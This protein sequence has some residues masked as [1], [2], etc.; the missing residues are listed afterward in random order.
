MTRGRAVIASAAFVVLTSPSC[1]LNLAKDQAATVSTNQCTSDSDCGTGACFSGACVAT[2]GTL[3]TLL[4]EVTPPTSAQGVGGVRFLQVSTGLARSSEGLTVDLGRVSTVHGFVRASDALRAKGCNLASGTLAVEVTLTPKQQSYGLPTV[5]YVARTQATTVSTACQN[6]IPSAAG[7]IQEFSLSVPAGSYDV[8]VRPL[9]TTTAGASSDVTDAGAGTIAGCTLPPEIVHG[10]SP[11][12]GDFCLALSATTP[13]E[14]NVEVPW[15]A[16][17]ATLDGWTVQVVHPVTGE[18]LSGTTTLTGRPSAIDSGTGYTTTVDYSPIAGDDT[19][20]AGQELL[21]LSPKDP[22]ASPVVQLELA[23]LQAFSANHK[24][25]LPIIGPFPDP[26]TVDSWVWYAATDPP[27]PALGSVAFAATALD[28]IAGG[29]FASFSTTAVVGTDGHLITKV[30][31]GEY[32]VRVTPTVGQHLASTE[33]SESIAS[34]ATQAGRALLVPAA[35]TVTGRVRM[36][37]GN[38]ALD[39]ASV[40]ASPA[41]VGLRQCEEGADAAAC[42]AEPLGVLNVSL[43][44][45]A[46]VPRLA[47]G[48]VDGGKLTLSDV[49]CGGCTPSTAASFDLSVEP[50]DGSRLPWLIRRSVSVSGNLDLGV[51]RLPFPVIQHG[52]VEIPLDQL[53]SGAKEPA[54]VR[55]ALVRAYVILDATGAP[56][57]DPTGLVSCTSSSAPTV[58]GKTPRCIRS[59]LQVA[60][61]RAGDDGTFELVVPSALDAGP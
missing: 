29:V 41:T 47:N 5:S 18:L 26:V 15:P 32:R 42:A 25:V 37:V 40:Q 61:T 49:D 4:L 60:E 33:A 21:R 8:Y 2:E 52:V 17:G 44:E 31:P 3:S 43:A 34:D 39:S 14:L 10:I 36:P 7:D 16:S 23:G 51:M 35:A 54:P 6:S 53:P 11:T 59:V 45:D 50:A 24:A 38:G 56:I 30:L 22:S 55:G 9:A 48:T 13:K 57:L 58:S 20:V 19:A 27:K 28:N 12:T 1:S 46:F